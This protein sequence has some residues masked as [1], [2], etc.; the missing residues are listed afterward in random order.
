MTSEQHA[1]KVSINKFAYLSIT[2][3]DIGLYKA[4]LG[5]ADLNESRI[6]YSAE[7]KLKLGQGVEYVG[8]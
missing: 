7:I 1:G 4:E 3:V 5:F 8:I 6:V 2:L